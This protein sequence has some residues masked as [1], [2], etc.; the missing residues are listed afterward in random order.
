MKPYFVYITTKDK[1]EAAKIGQALVESRL[2]AC[3]NIINQIDSIYWWEGKVQQDQETSLIAKTTS[4]K[5][6]ALIDK[7]KSLHS[8]SC[9]CIVALPI[10]HGNP[11]FLKWIGQ[12]TQ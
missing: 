11:A 3:V 4:E 2:A 8:Y 1:A 7:V 5:I 9:P 10:E 6:Q 12:E